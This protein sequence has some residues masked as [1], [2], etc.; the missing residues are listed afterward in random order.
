MAP[1]AIDQIYLTFIL[2]DRFS[3]GSTSFYFPQLLLFHVKS[4]ESA[5]QSS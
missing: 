1:L 2:N 3:L 5:D 4:Y